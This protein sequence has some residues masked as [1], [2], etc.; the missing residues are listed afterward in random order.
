MNQVSKKPH[1]VYNVDRAFWKH[2]RKINHA[3]KEIQIFVNA[4]KSMEEQ[5]ENRVSTDY[6]KCALLSVLRELKA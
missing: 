3:Q 1:E 4:V 6:M 2:D 5:G